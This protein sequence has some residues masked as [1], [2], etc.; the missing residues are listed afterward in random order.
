MKS[1]G[2]YVLNDA[3][4]SICRINLANVENPHSLQDFKDVEKLA[5][6]V[7]RLFAAS[8]GML[9]QLESIRDWCYPDAGRMPDDPVARCEWYARRLMLI[10]NAATAGIQKTESVA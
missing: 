2:I 9:T 5:T 10:A 3:N 1:S 8:E 6:R 7:A 4:F